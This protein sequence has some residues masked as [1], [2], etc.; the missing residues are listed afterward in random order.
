[1]HALEQSN[2]PNKIVAVL[3]NHEEMGDLPRILSIYDRHKSRIDLLVNKSVAITRDGATLRIVGVDFPMN[4][5]GGHLLP[6]PELNAAM[7]AQADAA[8][9]GLPK[10]ETILALSH[11]PAF[12]EF[13]AAHGAQLTLASHTHG[14]QLRLFGR[15]RSTHTG[16]CKGCIGAETPTSMSQ[17]ALATGCRYASAFHAKL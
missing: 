12:F 1:M 7:S 5:R 14:G 2:A 15:P 13:A 9:A 16:I 3:G 10:G 4:P 8:F 11:H 17:R 6:R